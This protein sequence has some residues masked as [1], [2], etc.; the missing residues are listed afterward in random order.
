VLTKEDLQKEA[1]D[2]HDFITKSNKFKS[3][4]KKISRRRDRLD[5]LK[6]RYNL[7]LI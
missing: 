1:K 3:V 5:I 2:L 6:S 4:I 7:N